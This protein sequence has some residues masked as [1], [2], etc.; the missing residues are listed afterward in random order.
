MF[1]PELRRPAS[2]A[3]STMYSQHPRSVDTSTEV[4][5]SCF[6]AHVDWVCLN[7]WTGLLW[8]S[9]PCVDIHSK[10]CPL[11][12]W[13]LRATTGQRSV[14]LLSNN[15]SKETEH[16]SII[17]FRG[18]DLWS[19]FWRGSHSLKGAEGLQVSRGG[20]LSSMIT[21]VC[22]Y[23]TLIVVLLGTILGQNCLSWPDL[24]CHFYST[25][26]CSELWNSEIISK[27]DSYV[28]LGWRTKM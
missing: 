1:R 7:F 28:V 13:T 18:R 3:C 14:G 19:S 15:D 16:S 22:V 26:I 12:Y 2:W 20:T 5:L 6:A 4:C 24:C 27:R 23:L 8:K 10:T 25:D 21:L 11:C 17:L 9:T